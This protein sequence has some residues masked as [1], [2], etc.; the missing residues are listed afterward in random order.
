MLASHM[1]SALGSASVLPM[2]EGRSAQPLLERA[3]LRLQVF[4]KMF[5]I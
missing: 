2:L 5:D 4:L 3:E 1:Y